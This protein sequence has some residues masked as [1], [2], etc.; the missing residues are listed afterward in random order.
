M[1]LHPIAKETVYEIVIKPRE[2]VW[3]GWRKL[4]RAWSIYDNMPWWWRV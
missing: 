1:D 3:C 4:G 2:Y